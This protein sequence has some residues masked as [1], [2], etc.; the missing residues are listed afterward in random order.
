MGPLL[1]IAGKDLK[2]RFRDRSAIALG[3]IAPLVI[4]AL[5]SL[6][7]RST[8]SFHATVGY[9]SMDNGPAATALHD[10]VTGPRLHDTFTVKPFADEAA[11]RRAVHDHKV[12]AAI[13]V[14]AGFSAAVTS[15]G[16]AHVA[17]LG[18]TDS[19]L[20]TG[21][22]QSVVEGFLTRVNADRMAVGAAV[23]NG[24]AGATSDLERLAHQAES[25]PLP[26]EVTQGEADAKRLKII[27]YYAPAMGIFFV[28]FAIGFGARG[29]FL[30]RDGGTLDRMRAAPIPLRT[31]LLGKS[32]ST[33]VYALGS[34]GT[35]ALVS[36]LA[37][38]A[39]WGNPLAVGC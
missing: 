18:T 36:S 31:L 25:T 32:L 12:E 21:V 19:D 34:L 17:V 23:V 3:F 8:D 38:G 27:S 9:A 37:F 26:V 14:P 11:A 13:V 35:T 1:A 29:W 33:F 2:Q 39:N 4:A 7:F 10:L 16:G 6:A 20:A 5:M 15:A 22:V 30:E 24:H 28:L